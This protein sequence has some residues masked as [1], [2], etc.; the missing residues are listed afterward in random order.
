MRGFLIK[1]RITLCLSLL[2]FA[3]FCRS[4]DIASYLISYPQTIYEA[5]K[6]PLQWQTEDWHKAGCIIF[7][8]SS[9][10][11]FD[12]EINDLVQK[13]AN[14]VSNSVSDAVRQFGNGRYMLSALVLTGTGGYIF[15]DQTLQETALLGIKS[16][17]LANGT[18]IS[19]KYLTQRRRPLSEEGK[20]FW[21]GEGFVRKRDSF[22]SGHA[23]VVWS[24]APIIAE[25]YKN[26]KLVPPLAYSIA[27][28]TSLSRINDEKHWASDVFT[29]AVIGYYS[30]QLV[31][32]TTPLF[33]VQP[34]TDLKS[35]Q[36]SFK[37]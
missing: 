24:L 21:N 26:V 3:L 13:N 12:G 27:A 29:G 2:S 10:Y 34:G 22:P 20:Q 35:L 14:S 23:T 15:H 5:A 9:L 7:I 16:F 32:K 28:L 11:L 25:Q 17:F 33:S 18:S 31:L 1:K 8:G 4:N 6:S 19:L 37:F 36:I 30:S